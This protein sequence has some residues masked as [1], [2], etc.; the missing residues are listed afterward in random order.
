MYVFYGAMLVFN[1]KR[2]SKYSAVDEKSSAQVVKMMYIVDIQTSDVNIKSSA[3]S[4]KFSAVY[5]M[6]IP[7]VTGDAKQIWKC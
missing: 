6:S 2:I 3:V 1:R 4:I 5:L 7:H